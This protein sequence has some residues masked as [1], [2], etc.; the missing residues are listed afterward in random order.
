ME[1]YTYKRK[2]V[3]KIIIVLI[4][5]AFFVLLL[6]YVLNISNYNDSMYSTSIIP[7]FLIMFICPIL[8]VIW[9][10]FGIKSIKEDSKINLK[11]KV[12]NTINTI[13]CILIIFYYVIYSS[14]TSVSRLYVIED[15]VK[16]QG[17]YVV[18]DYLDDDLR[19]KCRKNEFNLIEKGKEYLISFKVY[20]FFNIQAELEYIDR[21]E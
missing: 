15:K 18:I 5:I 6:D 7:I 19:L 4:Y 13:F 16:E 14:Y 17:Y 10:F 20:K 11:S 9:I 8:L 1:S 12:I 3:S 21:I 2:F